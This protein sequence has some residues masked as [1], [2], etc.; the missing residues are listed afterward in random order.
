MHRKER[1]L[2]EKSRQ[3]K[4]RKILLRVLSR[5]Y[6]A[7]GEGYEIAGVYSWEYHSGIQ[8]VSAKEWNTI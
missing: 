1:Y 5:S 3:Q 2:M 8:P 6:V 4:K 7:D